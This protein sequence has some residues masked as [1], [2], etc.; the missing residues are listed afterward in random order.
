MNVFDKLRQYLFLRQLRRQSARD[1]R[2]PKWDK[3]RTI[4]LIYDSDL[5]EKNSDIKMCSRLSCRKVA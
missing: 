5:M 2:F 4:L 3:V 1:V